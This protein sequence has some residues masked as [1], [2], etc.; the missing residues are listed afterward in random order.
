MPYGGGFATVPAYLAEMFGTQMVGATHGLLLTAWSAAEILDPVLIANIQAQIDAGVPHTLVYDRML[1]I[2]AGVL[3]VGF[4]SNLHVKP[5]AQRHHMMG[6]GAR[7]RAATRRSGN[8]LGRRLH[9]SPGILRGRG[10]PRVAG[11]RH[12]LPGRSLH[13]AQQGR[14]P[15]PLAADA[16]DHARRAPAAA[17]TT[18]IQPNSP[19]WPATRMWR[20]RVRRP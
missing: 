5:V 9:G 4:V 17:R 18:L 2:L 3:A 8:E 13:R 20:A 10:R 7:T 12:S 15:V 6:T 16:R 14:R 19:H 1:Y 11:R